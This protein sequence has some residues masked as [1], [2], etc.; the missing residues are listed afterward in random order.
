MIE[1]FRNQ[2]QLEDSKFDAYAS[3]FNRIEVPAK[4]TLLNEGEISK[5]MFFIEKGC[6][7][8]WFNNDGK[9][10]TCQ[11]F[12]EQQ[13]VGAIESFKKNIPALTTIETIEPSV[14]WWIHQQDA[15]MIIA[16]IKEIPH[17]RDLFIDKIFERTFD[18]MKYFFS[19][20]KD[21]PQERYLRLLAER[22]ELIRRV[23]QHYIASYMG[24]S[25]VHLS[26]IKSKLSRS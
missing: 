4:T 6:I 18:Y 20:I 7:R 17:L 9:D 11:F 23:P 10:I 16:E 19:V 12:F 24:I 1:Q 15:Y 8:E 14:L 22:P 3:C 5:R 13:A 2:F 26:R 21:S 25:T